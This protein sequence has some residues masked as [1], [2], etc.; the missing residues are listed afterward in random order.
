MLD[1]VEPRH[2]AA[3]LS[4]FAFGNS[5]T[6]TLD[7]ADIAPQIRSGQAIWLSP[8]LQPDFELARQRLLDETV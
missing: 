8:E 4:P 1:V 5:E 6:I 3:F 2:I 7:L